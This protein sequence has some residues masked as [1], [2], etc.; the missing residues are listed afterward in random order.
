MIYRKTLVLT[1]VLL[2]LS[3]IFV[4]QETREVR[5]NTLAIPALPEGVDGIRISEG[6]EEVELTRQGE[7]WLVGAEGYTADEQLVSQLIEAVRGLGEVEVVSARG[8]YRQY[9]LAGEDARSL[10][11]LQEGTELLTLT[12]GADAAAG[13]AVYARVN[14]Q[15]Q[16]LLLPRVIRERTP[17]EVREFRQTVMGSIE[18]G[19]ILEATVSAGGEVR[20]T[21]T[22]VTDPEIP[23]GASRLEEIDAS[24]QA[25]GGESVAAEDIRDFLLELENIRA[26]DFLDEPPSEPAFATLNLELSGGEREEIR[27]Y[28]PREGE[29]VPVV[30]STSEYPFLLNL[31]RARR[32]LLGSEE[33][34][35]PFGGE[36]S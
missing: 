11:I 13:G 3:A 26:R 16:V 7:S 10:T 30:S 19:S 33:L 25:D 24:W 14:G 23:P 32:L 20:A 12:L 1:A 4:F 34:F 18:E 29:L 6:S 31:W 35:A 15:P 27:F 8:N 17:L 5:R 36:E 28:P 9:D 21:L 2:I 22:P